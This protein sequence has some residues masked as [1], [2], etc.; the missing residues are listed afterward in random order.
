[1]S[2]HTVTVVPVELPIPVAMAKDPPA[3]KIPAAR[4]ELTT[5]R[6]FC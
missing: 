3:T 4:T 5:Y 6:F 1:M 2:A